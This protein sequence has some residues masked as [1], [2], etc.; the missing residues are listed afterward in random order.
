MTRHIHT[1]ML[2]LGVLVLPS[3]CIKEDFDDCDNV[4]IHFRYLADGKQDVLSQY[5]KQINLYVFDESGKRVDMRQYGEGELKGSAINSSF[6]LTPG[7]RYKFVA[8]GNAY[9]RTEVKGTE[10]ETDLGKMYIHHPQSRGEARVDGQDHNYLGSEEITVPLTDK[11]FQVLR[12]TVTLFSAHINTDIEIF[13]LNAPGREAKAMPYTVRIEQANERTFLNRLVSTQYKTV[14]VP[15]LVY[16]AERACYH[17][18]EL[19]L[20][21]MDNGEGLSPEL[22]RHELVVEDAQT[23]QE[24]AREPLY[25]YIRSNTEHIQVTRQEAELPVAVHFYETNVEIKLPEWIIVDGKPE[26]N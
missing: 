10:S 4:E 14:C 6:R 9:S 3:S 16:D 20:F 1:L 22:C 19:A 25:D 13:G 26:W 7:S 2:L 11:E 24:L 8:V 15:E 5:V 21:R 23:G 18:V 12:D 17:T